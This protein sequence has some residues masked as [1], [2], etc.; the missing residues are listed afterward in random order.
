MASIEKRGRRLPGAVPRPARPAALAD[1]QPARP[2]PTASPARSRSTRSGA[3]GSIPRRRHRRSRRGPRRSCRCARRL[4]PTTQETYRRD[5]EPL[6]PAPVRRRT[7]SAGSR[8]RR[9]RT[10]STTSSPPACRRRRSIA[11]TGRLRRMLQVAVEKQKIA[12][13]TRATGSDPPRVPKREM[14]FLDWDQAVRLAEAHSE[15]LPGADLRRR[16]HGHALERAR[17]PPPIEGRPPRPQ[18]PGDR[19]AGPARG[20]FVGPQGTEDRR[21]RP[22]DHD[23]GRHGR[24]LADHLERVRSP[25]PRRAVFPTARATRSSSSSFRTHHFRKAQHAAGVS[26]RFHDLRHTSVALAI[27]DGAHPKAIQA[28]MGHSLDQ[29]HARP[30]RPSLP[31]ARRGDRRGVRPTAPRGP[32]A[33][34]EQRHPAPEVA[35]PGFRQARRRREAVVDAERRRHRRLLAPS[36][37]RDRQDAACFD[38]LFH[39]FGLE[40]DEVADL[41]VG[42]S[43]LGHEPSHESLGHREP[44]CDRRNVQECPARLARDQTARRC[45]CCPCSPTDAPRAA[46]ANF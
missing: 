21:R 10:G 20:R 41:E 26:C 7:G 46:R 23:L 2:T 9:S 14:V 24:V 35:R 29:R 34:G 40:T 32:A 12:R 5:L 25:G 6:R 13:T 15:P 3:T 36:A 33:P 37:V 27:A 19:A 18:D 39:L 45:S 38:P 44:C 8:P 28:R 30:L 31:R 42:D 1:L 43:A 11:T 16:R 17:R 4:S 22:L